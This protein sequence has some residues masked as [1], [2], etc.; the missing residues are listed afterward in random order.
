MPLVHKWVND[1]ICIF[2]SDNMERAIGW[3]ATA[4]CKAHFM[5]RCYPTLKLP[6]M[7]VPEPG[8]QVRQFAERD[9]DVIT[10]LLPGEKV[11]F[12]SKDAPIRRIDITYCGSI[13][14][15]PGQGWITV[16][17]LPV[18]EEGVPPQPAS[19]SDMRANF[20]R[21]HSHSLGA[22]GGGHI[23]PSAPASHCA[24]ASLR[25]DGVVPLEAEKLRGLLEARGVSLE[26]INMK[27][28]GD[29]EAA[30]ISGIEHCDTFIVF[31]SMKYGE[32]TGNQACT[33]YESKFAQDRKK[34]IILIRMIPFDQD[35][36]FP[37][38]RF[39]F[40][41]NKLVLPWMLGTPMPA[42]LVDKIVEAMEL[43]HPPA[44]AAMAGV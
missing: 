42:D 10:W 18:S 21:T 2:S 22:S 24:F 44:A 29:I 16:P 20:T 5:S 9:S 6:E 40:G 38:A 4:I 14:E 8:L 7:I 35:F 23:G 41:L 19:G 33:Y 12:R 1:Q 3:H 26:I 15:T 32:N 27:A 30:V 39:M 25:F 13:C 43:D 34:R 28:G 37:Q 17:P 36:E 11:K 31:G